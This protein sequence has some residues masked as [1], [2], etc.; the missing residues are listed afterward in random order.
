MNFRRY[1]MILAII[2]MLVVV[3]FVTSCGKD[4][5]PTAQ[6]TTNGEFQEKIELEFWTFWGSEARRPLIEKLVDNFN[7]SQ[8]EIN[9]T[10][11][12]LPW[13]DIWT[14]EI[15]QI[16]AGNPPDVIVNH[17]TTAMRAEA[18]QVENLLPY[19]EADPDF[20]LDEFLP[21]YIELQKYEDGVW[22]LPFVTDVRLIYYNKDHFREAGLDPEKPLTT[23]AE[24]QQAAFQLDKKNS[25]GTYE[26]IGFHPMLGNGK[27][28]IWFASATQGV[29]WYDFEKDEPVVNTPERVETLEWI[30]SFTEHYGRR[31]VSE[32]EA[33]YGSG[34]QDPF[35]SGRLSMVGHTPAFKRV[36]DTSEMDF[37]YGVMLI[38]EFKKGTGHYSTSGGFS[39]E[40]PKGAK[41]PEASYEFIKYMAGAEAQKFWGKNNYELSTRK[42]L[43]EDPELMEDLVYGTSLK[44]L[45][46]GSIIR[47]PVEIPTADKDFIDPI[48]DEILLGTI[49]PAD[50][51]AK[52]EK[53]V[54]DEWK[55]KQ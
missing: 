20:S 5:T 43:L 26:R 3:G 41:N 29:L 1:S 42:D 53:I 2:V 14:K 37:E 47:F 10:H 15:A 54:K 40:I 48:L 36:L 50:G 19:I 13:G 28:G 11:M 6:T 17:L 33:A 27:S 45:P 30:L 51:L 46:N 31:T 24:F 34:M 7:N 22:A 38:P 9:V 16:A 18:G 55:R 32:Y 44:A 52:A 4:D 49:S 21:Q 23:W 39:I 25:D 8:D 12:F 35:V